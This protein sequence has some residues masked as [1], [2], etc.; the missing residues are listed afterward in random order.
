[1][2]MVFVF[3]ALLI[4]LAL[5]AAAQYGRGGRLSPEDQQRFDNYYAKWQNDMR[6]NDRDDV[7]P[8]APDPRRA[9]RPF[10][11]EPPGSTSH[12]RRTPVLQQLAQLRADDHVLAFVRSRS[13]APPGP[14]ALQPRSI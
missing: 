5:P 14:L 4:A 13:G 1:M 7:V 12:A 3:S 9:R 10:R 8:L 6:R 11:P 2:K